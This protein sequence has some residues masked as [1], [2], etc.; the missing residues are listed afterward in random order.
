M[1][2][3]WH[4]FLMLTSH[5]ENDDVDMESYENPSFPFVTVCSLFVKRSLLL[6]C[7]YIINWNR[8]YRTRFVQQFCCSGNSETHMHLEAINI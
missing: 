3:H 6:D 8:K 7:T 5:T 2:V 4:I 1:N